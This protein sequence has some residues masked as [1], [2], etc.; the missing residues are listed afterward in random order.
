MLDRSG[1]RGP[2]TQDAPGLIDRLKSGDEAG[3]ALL[4]DGWSSGMQRLARA[5]VGDEATAEEVVQE[6]WL[7]VIAN[8]AALDGRTSFKQWVYRILVSTAQHRASRDRG[9]VPVAVDDLTKD[10]DPTVPGSR[11]RPLGG[12]FPGHWTEPPARWPMPEGAVQTAELR[13]VVA[14]AVRRL[15][16]AQAAVLILRD[17][18]GNATAETSAVLDLTAANQ[19][20][21]LHRAR[22]AVRAAIEEYFDECVTDRRLHDSGDR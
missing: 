20:M 12:S 19:L 9:V 2:A 6:T 13:R 10:H 11:F 7:A 17:I 16:S 15:P 1:S 18:E 21:L 14:D 22:A 3:F 5:Y 4:L 8:I